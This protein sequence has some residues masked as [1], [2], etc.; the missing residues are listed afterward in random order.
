VPRLFAP[1]VVAARQQ[2]TKTGW[3]Y[4]DVLPEGGN[5]GFT[6]D[7]KTGLPT[8]QMGP[9]D[10]GALPWGVKYQAIDPTHPNGNFENFRKAMLRSQCAGMPGANYSTMASDYE[11]INFSAGRL[12]KLDSN[13]MFKLI[14]T[15]DI[16]YAER[17]IFEAWLE[18]AL[19]TRAI[20]LPLAKYEKFN[21]KEFSGRR[22]Q[23][24]DAVKDATA[25]ALRVANK[26]S[27]RTRECADGGVDFEEVLFELAEEEMQIEQFG[28]KTETTVET[29]TPLPTDNADPNQSDAPTPKK[30][31]GKGRFEVA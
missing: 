10:I 8:Q 2:A 22:W 3:L 7:P 13:E 5:A 20:P 19:L 30:S 14:Q 17:P 24:V 11:A 6:V 18:M 15:F 12:Q 16:D 25:S 4:S 31:K 29:P 1:E 26:F 9:G 21:R 23:G 28:L 27:S